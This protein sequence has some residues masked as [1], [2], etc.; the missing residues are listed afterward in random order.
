MIS[1]PRAGACV[2]AAALLAAGGCTA[3]RSP[4]EPVPATRLNLRVLSQPVELARPGD[5][6]RALR[7]TVA[8][9]SGSRVRVGPGGSALLVGPGSTT[10][11]A[12]G[13]EL[14]L[15]AGHVVLRRG[16]VLVQGRL[17]LEAADATIATQGAVR[18][19]RGLT[20]RVGAYE[21]SADI[22]FTARRLTVAR[23]REIVFSPGFFPRASSPLRVSGPDAWD[24]RILADELELDR[25]L[26]AFAVG[27]LPR[28]QVVETGIVALVG[29]GISAL[30][31]APSAPL[32]A[33]DKLLASAIAAAAPGGPNTL[34]VA[35]ALRSE[36][37][38]W[39]VVAATLGARTEQVLSRLQAAIGPQSPPPAATAA[40][41]GTAQP[42][43]RPAT[44]GPSTPSPA[45]P[46]P[47]PTPTPGPVTTLICNAV[48]IC[49]EV[50]L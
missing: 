43:P 28:P 33:V 34:S 22:S 19:D 1:I 9:S 50:P 12:P 35:F 42:T 7:A 32:P 18:L 40:P 39:A 11:A 13:A 2:A 10:E 30:P 37:A 44:P 3:Q 27:L 21:G 15:R 48:G 6:Y 36:G 24:R 41:A 38:A 14:E 4:R 46:R 25:S 20:V 5:E 23:Y 16:S 49:L 26:N 47:S 45:P 17:G 8:I 29:L 31:P